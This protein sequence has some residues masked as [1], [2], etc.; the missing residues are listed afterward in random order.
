M[1]KARLTELENK[2]PDVSGLVTK[3]AL[4]ADG[5]KIRLYTILGKSKETVLEFYEGT[6]KVLWIV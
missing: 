6:A 2:I 4:T 3:S 1:K 5:I